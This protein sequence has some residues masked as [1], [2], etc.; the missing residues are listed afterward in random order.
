M[1]RPLSRCLWLTAVA[2]VVLA[3]CDREEIHTY[4]APKPPSTDVRLL[5]GIIQNGNKEMWFF[6]LV[7][8]KDQISNFKDDFDKFLTTIR[9]TN[10]PKNPID[11]T[12]LPE[13]WAWE[14][15]PP[16][17]LTWAKIFPLG[18]N[19]KRPEMTVSRFGTISPILRNV[20]RWA[21]KDVGLSKLT[22]ADLKEP[23][24]RKIKLAAGQDLYLIDMTGPGP[25]VMA[26]HPPM[27]GGD[28]DEPQQPNRGKQP[29]THS[30]PEGWVEVGGGGGAFG[31]FKTFAIRTGEGAALLK[32]SSLGNFQVN[33]ANMDR[34]RGEVK[35]PASQPDS[36]PDVIKIAGSSA[37]LYDM[38]G[39]AGPGQKRSLIVIAPRKGGTW[40][41]KLIGD[42][43]VVAKNR[44]KFNSF[45][46][47]IKFTGAA[48]E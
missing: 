22:E 9:F 48:D 39:P 23:L 36:K 4:T 1:P 20:N 2:L 12:S 38:T 11:W 40:F 6:K 7:G 45:L 25:R 19:R 18:E 16:G 17:G 14:I 21:Q 33:K 47:S 43:D 42:A 15:M 37:E 24:V 41:F 13:G 46:Q 29:F 35:M 8:L 5:A 32:I 31:A 28:D 34:W 27:M 44:D 30:T 10:D 26:G 3:G